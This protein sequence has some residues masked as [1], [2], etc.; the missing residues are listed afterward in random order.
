MSCKHC[1]KIQDEGSVAYYRLGDT[2]IGFGNV[3]I[4]GCDDHVGMAFLAFMAYQRQKQSP[5]TRFA[6]QIVRL[7][8]RPKVE[9]QAPEPFNKP[10]SNDDE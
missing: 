5:H 7:S 3:G 1:D 10:T 9:K 4:V 8:E 6:R 2:K